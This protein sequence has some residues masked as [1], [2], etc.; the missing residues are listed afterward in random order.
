M[1]AST[2]FDK[3]KHFRRVLGFWDLMFY[4]IVIIQPTAPL[5]S[6]GIVNT[7]S[8]GHAVTAILLAMIFNGIGAAAGAALL[9]AA[10]GRLSR[11][12]QVYGGA[13]LFCI[14]LQALSL[15]SAFWLVLGLLVV[16]GFAM[17]VFGM[18]A[19][20]LVQEE[21]PDEL[22]G[23]VMAVYSLVFQGLFPVGGVE[24]GFLANHYGALPAIRINATICLVIT[25]LILAWSLSARRRIE[26]PPASDAS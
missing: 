17:I 4:G 20:T 16:S 10:G 25:L 24:I 3:P 2:T 15:V 13:A 1:T 11:R 9:A 12:W 5:P 26:L 8:R 19:Q 7:V 6:F 18:A 21:V 22:R 23:R 14:S